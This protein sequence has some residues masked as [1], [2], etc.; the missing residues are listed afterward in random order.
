MDAILLNSGGI[1]SRVCAAMLVEQGWTVHSLLIDWNVR[2][3]PAIPEAAKRT[4]DLYCASHE[5]M[6][7]DRDWAC[8]NP[9]QNGKLTSQ[10]A[11]LTTTMLGLQYAA[12]IGDHVE[13]VVNGSRAEG[14]GLEDYPG[15]VREIVAA[16]RIQTPRV[17]LYPLW[18]MS[19][20]QVADEGRLRGVELETTYSCSVFPACGTCTSCIRRA[21]CL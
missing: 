16:N 3:R 15:K 18:E 21:S 12:F 20:G 6:T 9:R 19:C 11:T 7:P 2:G 17:V 14:A 5:V 1:D 10:Y 4:A 13:Y 8:P